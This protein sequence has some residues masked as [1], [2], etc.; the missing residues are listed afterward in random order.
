MYKSR[1]SK[2]DDGLQFIARTDALALHESLDAGDVPR[3]WLVWSSA[4]EA[5]LADACRFAGGPMPE[6]GLVMGRGTARMRTVRLGGHMVRPARRNAADVSGFF[7][8]T[9]A[10][11]QA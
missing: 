4:A 2:S 8:C 3:A 1:G 5:A 9:P 7:C 10:E 6:K 11:S